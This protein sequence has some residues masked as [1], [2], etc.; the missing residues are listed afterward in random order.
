MKATIYVADELW[1]RAASFVGQG[2]G[3]STLV[4]EALKE[5]AEARRPVELEPFDW[6]EDVTDDAISAAESLREQA[7]FRYA[8]GYRAGVGA[9]ERLTPVAFEFLAER[10]WDFELWST[11]VDLQPPD[12]PSRLS[13][14]Q[15]ADVELLRT[16]LGGLT[17][18][19]DGPRPGGVWLRGFTAALRD[20]WRHATTPAEI[21]WM[22]GASG[23]WKKGGHVLH[24]GEGLGRVEALRAR[25][26][27]HATEAF[28]RF[29]SGTKY[30]YRVGD[31]ELVALGE[32]DL[33]ELASA[34]QD[35]VFEK[36][37]AKQAAAAEHVLRVQERLVRER[38]ARQAVSA[39]E[40]AGP[41][42]N[43]GGDAGAPPQNH[44]RD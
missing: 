21:T 13:A 22:I 14:G 26:S 20:I 41:R 19:F 16:Y 7:Q 2:V 37:A 4:Q 28:V 25:P 31:P 27:D 36:L 15:A 10:D 32:A 43:A 3:P 40:A 6:P 33:A 44:A 23:H 8:D 42:P 1:E 5:W 9:G 18:P 30:R 24:R 34:G 17:S 29:D 39:N 38:A 35:A 12:L 11:T